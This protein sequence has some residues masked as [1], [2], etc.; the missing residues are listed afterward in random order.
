M[1]LS[2]ILSMPFIG[3]LGGLGFFFAAILFLP[4]VGR[5]NDYL[6][7]FLVFVI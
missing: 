2:I 7:W 4:D 3:I 5:S 1:S 6:L